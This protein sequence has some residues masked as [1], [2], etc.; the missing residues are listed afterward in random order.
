MPNP[1][2]TKGNNRTCRN[3]T[4][5][6]QQRMPAIHAF[7]N[8]SWTQPFQQSVQDIQDIS[9]AGNYDKDAAEPSMLAQQQLQPLTDNLI[10]RIFLPFRKYFSYHTILTYV[11]N[12]YA[13]KS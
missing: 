13:G 10:H 6:V 8:R 5:T 3:G 9:K 11:L 1:T 2:N 7:S 12:T 4:Q